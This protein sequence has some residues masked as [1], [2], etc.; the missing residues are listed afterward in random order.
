MATIQLCSMPTD[1]QP[2]GSL[3]VCR[4]AHG[5]ETY[6]VATRF[7]HDPASQTFEKPSDWEYADDRISELCVEACAEL[8]TE[9]KRKCLA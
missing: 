4:D 2:Y 9:M 3:S 7:F 8:A 1:Q 6:S 5:E